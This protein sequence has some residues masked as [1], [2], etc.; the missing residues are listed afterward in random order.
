MASLHYRTIWLSDIHLGSRGCNAEFL[1]DFLTQVEAERL[2]LV[3]DI[4][5]FWKLKNGWYWPKLQNE[6]VRNVL[7]KAANGTEVIYIPGNH[8]EFFRDYVGKNFGGIRIEAQAIHVTED[9]RRF[10]VLHGDEFDSIVCHSKWVALI[11]GHA[12]DMLL[13]FNRWFNFFRRKLGFPYW[14]LSAYLKHKVKN[15]VNFISNYE[16]A[17]VHEAKRQGVGGIICGH[18]HKATVEDFEGV[19][20]CN[21]GDWVESCT[22]LVEN[23]AGQLAIL[24]WADESVF[25]INEDAPASI[26]RKRRLVS[27]N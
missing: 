24:H 7:Q 19:L 5:D 21:T 2:Y 18:I 8:D 9:G 14:S 15:A 23:K 20:Y 13:V 3:G 17:L 1:L 22:A 10:L 26:E 27:T 12:Y 6:V 25:L 16:Q 11:G 4:I